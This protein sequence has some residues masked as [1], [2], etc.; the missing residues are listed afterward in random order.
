LAE[1]EVVIE[2]LTVGETITPEPIQEKGFFY[3]LL[4]EISAK[5]V[6]QF[7]LI[8]L[9]IILLIWYIITR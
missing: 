2:N 5:N 9:V 6:V 4:D 8:A 1:E 7:L 3:K